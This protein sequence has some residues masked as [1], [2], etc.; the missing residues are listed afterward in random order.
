VH[1]VVAGLNRAITVATGLNAQWDH[2]YRRMGKWL[3]GGAFMHAGD[4]NAAAGLGGVWRSLP[5]LS[6]ATNVPRWNHMPKARFCLEPG[7]FPA[8]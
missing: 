1:P 7:S 3:D 4:A 2:L 5:R 8:A 6:R